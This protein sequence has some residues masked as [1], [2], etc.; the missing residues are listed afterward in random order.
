MSF[1]GL[2]ALRRLTRFSMSHC[3]TAHAAPQVSVFKVAHYRLAIPPR[4][5]AIS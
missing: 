1:G 5:S 2:T 3:G 4:I